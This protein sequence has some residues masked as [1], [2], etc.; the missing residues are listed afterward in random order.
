MVLGI[1]VG[2]IDVAVIELEVSVAEMKGSVAETDVSIA[3]DSDAIGP[4]AAGSQT[5]QRTGHTIMI[6]SVVQRVDGSEVHFIWSARPLHKTSRST[7]SNA[8]VEPIG[9]TVEEVRSVGVVGRE[10]NVETA[11]PCLH[12]GAMKYVL[13]TE[14]PP[15]VV[16]PSRSVWQLPEVRLTENATHLS[17]TACNDSRHTIAQLVGA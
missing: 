14:Y 2:A 3:D 6:R 1:E 5:L 17:P 4:V 11:I 12:C 13:K 15:F 16:A 9:F 8:V 10:M 7:I